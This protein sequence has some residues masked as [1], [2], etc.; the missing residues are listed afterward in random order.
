LSTLHQTKPT[1]KPDAQSAFFAFHVVKQSI[2]SPYF[3]VRYARTSQVMAV[4]AAAGEMEGRVPLV[5]VSVHER[6]LDS[7]M[8][9]FCHGS[10]RQI[11]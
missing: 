4:E 11:H 8:K 7:S 10:S 9:V 2:I 1:N 3:C 5:P 6:R